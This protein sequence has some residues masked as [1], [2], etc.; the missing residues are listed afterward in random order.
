L[1]G[2][3]LDSLDHDSFRKLVEQP[4]G[5]QLAL[6]AEA[7]AE[8]LVEWRDEF[9]RGDPMKRWPR[10]AAALIPIVAGR[11]DMADWYGD[12]SQVGK[13]VWESALLEVLAEPALGLK[14][15]VESQGVEY[16][17]VDAVW[18]LLGVVPG[19]VSDVALS[20]FGSRPF[21]YQPPAGSG[22][23]R[24]EYDREAERLRPFL[25]A[26]TDVLTGSLRG[27]PLFGAPTEKP[28]S[29]EELLQEFEKHEGLSPADKQQFAAL[30]SDEPFE[31][32]EDGYQWTPSHSIHPPDEV[33]RIQDELRSLETRINADPRPEVRKQYE[34]ELMPAIDRVAAGG[35][36]LLVLEYT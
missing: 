18:K 22:R 30:L 5:A 32:D 26:A 23:T 25:E 35:R 10:K 8:E 14:R 12:L 1:A 28:K 36:M 13:E 33:K 2:Y 11:L 4:T 20:A 7:L 19:T 31:G 3:F 29:D 21:R 17:V 16:E 6:L 9:E 24:E 15:A 27:L 34:A